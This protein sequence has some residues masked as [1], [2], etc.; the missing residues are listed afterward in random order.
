MNGAALEGGPSDWRAS[1]EMDNIAPPV[2]T[3][4]GAGS[5]IGHD[6]KYLAVCPREQSC[7]CASKP[8]RVLYKGFE[9]GPEIKRRAT[10]DLQNISSSGLLFQRLG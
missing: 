3:Y 6:P 10:D 9:H 8:C 2:F 1:A 7:L 5:I 4:L